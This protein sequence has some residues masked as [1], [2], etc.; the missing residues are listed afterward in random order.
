MQFLRRKFPKISEE[1]ITT[2]VLNGPQI[3][4]L[5]KDNDFENSMNV[6]TTWNAFK[7]II[8]DFLGNQCEDYV[9]LVD[10]LMECMEILGSRMSIMMHFLPSHL[11][12]FPDNCGDFSEEQW[13]IFQLDISTMEDR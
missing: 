10:K 5:I 11:D 2:G 12:Y 9:K 1:K 8:T 13:G 3:R 6:H 7:W 4:E